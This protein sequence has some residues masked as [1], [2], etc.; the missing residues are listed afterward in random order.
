M[1]LIVA[2][3]LHSFRSHG[4]WPVLAPA[5]IIL[6]LTGCAAVL[7]LDYQPSNTVK[8]QGGVTVGTFVYQGANAGRL[9]PKEVHTNPQGIGKVYLSQDVAVFV[10]EAVRSELQRSGY[11]VTAGAEREVAGTITRF[12]LDWVGAE[13]VRFEVD[14]EYT[15]HLKGLRTYDQTIRS[16]Q[17]SPKILVTQG[18][19]IKRA[20]ADCIQQFLDQAA[21]EGAL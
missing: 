3:S 20:V 9:S 2:I 15:V 17:T 18:A 10:A 19:L 6:G 8:G 14:V 7:S 21:M 4:P 5:A 13:E 12:Y 16:H 1:H 11:D